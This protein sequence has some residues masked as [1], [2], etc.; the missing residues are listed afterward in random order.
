[1]KPFAK[2]EIPASVLNDIGKVF[3]YFNSP[4]APAF[5]KYLREQNP[6]AFIFSNIK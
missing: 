3:P 2:R 5:F 6:G 4:N 1:M